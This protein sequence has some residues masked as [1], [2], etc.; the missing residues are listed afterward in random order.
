VARLKALSTPALKDELNGLKASIKESEAGLFL[1]INLRRDRPDVW[2]KLKMIK[3]SSVTIKRDDLPYFATGLAPT[4]ET[5]TFL[6]PN[7]G[8][9]V[10]IDG[11]PIDDLIQDGPIW[12]HAHVPS[13]PQPLPVFDNPF[14]FNVE[15]A[16]MGAVKDLIILVKYNL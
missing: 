7:S 4:I 6:T 8:F 11:P 5:V 12:K 15:A 2:H 13:Q 14:V 3:S 1:A 10:A 16:D 9:K